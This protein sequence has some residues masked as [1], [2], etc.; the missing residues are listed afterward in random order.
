MKAMT[1][2]RTTSEEK[3]ADN[4]ELN[5]SAGGNSELSPVIQSFLSRV[6]T[7]RKEYSLTWADHD[8]RVM[9]EYFLDTAQVSR[10]QCEFVSQPHPDAP[11]FAHMA[12]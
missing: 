12:N 2:R 6:L 7:E 4:S 3:A 8:I 9:Y 11:P 10:T 1:L 5:Y